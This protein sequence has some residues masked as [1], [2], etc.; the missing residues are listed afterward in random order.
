MSDPNPE[1]AQTTGPPAESIS[2]TETL[3]GIFFEPGR[4]FESFRER[5]R[6]IVAAII[7]AITFVLFTLLFFQRVGYERAIREAVESSPRADRL[8]PEQKE[9][10]I[11]LQS[12]PMFKAIYTASPILVTAIIIAGGGALYLLGVVL[13]GKTLSY[14]QAVAIWTYSSLPPVVIAKV[15]DMILI[16]IRS[17]DDYDIVQAWRR[18]LVLANLGF[19]VDPKASPVLGTILGSFDLFAFYGLFLATLG[20][21]KVAR[22][23]SG[24]AWSIVMAIWIIGIVLRVVLA[25]LTGGAV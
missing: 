7:I 12:G 20:L 22:L 23:S 18:G 3:S 15:L 25:I 4:V 14:K 2:T 9:Q 17:P 6:F 13:I 5:P 19:L 1:P 24:A 11:Q 10:Q 8:S 16:F 21:R